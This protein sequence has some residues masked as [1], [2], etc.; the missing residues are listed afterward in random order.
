MDIGHGDILILGYLNCLLCSTA[1]SDQW[2]KNG[3]E[4]VKR[5]GRIEEKLSS[6]LVNWCQRNANNEL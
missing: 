3:F 4:R 6:N 2:L 5:V 1:F